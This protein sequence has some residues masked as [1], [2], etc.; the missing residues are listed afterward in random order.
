MKKSNILAIVPARGGSK[1]L[2]RKNIRPLAGKPLIYY[3]IAEA[4]AC[5]LLD[6]VIVST[7]DEEIARIARS[8]SAEVILRPVELA[9]DNT[10]SIPVFR[11]V[12]EYLKQK[13]GYSADIIVILQ[14]TS[15]LRTKDDIEICIKK[16]LT[17]KCDSVISVCPVEHP[18]NWIYRL[19]NDR[20]T[21]FLEESKRVLRRQDAPPLYRLN[22]VVYVS[23]GDWIMKNDSM[24]GENSLAYVMPP[25]RS[26]DIDTEM[27]FAIAESLL[28]RIA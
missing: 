23:S 19:D 20:M 7:E 10:P 18:P 6:R 26:L 3:S 5:S 1:G 16:Y 4:K 27:D 24:V 2:P 22:G 28:K 25:E 12:V 21:P 8:Y 13:E 11:H 9:Q 17:H 15:P 14:P